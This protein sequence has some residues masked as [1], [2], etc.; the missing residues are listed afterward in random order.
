[1]AQTGGKQQILSFGANFKTKFSKLTSQTFTHVRFTVKTFSVTELIQ[2]VHFVSIKTTELGL[3]QLFTPKA[4]TVIMNSKHGRTGGS[5]RTRRLFLTL[6][7]SAD[8]RDSSASA[9]SKK[10]GRGK[11]SAV[12][13]ISWP[14]SP[15]LG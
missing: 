13:Q 5:I 14:Q 15:S 10:R 7:L 2:T 3:E 8:S 1:M 11:T 6:K 12:T 4:K 9:T